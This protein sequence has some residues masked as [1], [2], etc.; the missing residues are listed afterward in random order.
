ML[1]FA[2]DLISVLVLGIGWHF[3]EFFGY[4]EGNVSGS[5]AFAIGHFPFE[6]LFRLEV[7]R[8]I[9]WFISSETTQGTS[10]WRE[11][12]FYLSP[13]GSPWVFL[14]YALPR[15]VNTN[16]Y[17]QI[18]RSGGKRHFLFVGRPLRQCVS[19]APAPIVPESFPGSKMSKNGNYLLLL[20]CE[21]WQVLLLCGFDDHS[22]KIYWTPLLWYSQHWGN[23]SE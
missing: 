2:S 5:P 6:H 9:K 23:S 3:S 12:V 11:W 18:S 16:T 4:V 13:P 17:C 19:W 10:L 14:R 21:G 15:L 1:T 8:R 20:R 7:K 22:A